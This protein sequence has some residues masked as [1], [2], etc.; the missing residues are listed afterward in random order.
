MHGGLNARASRQR[1]YTTVLSVLARLHHKGLLRR[2]R[3]GRADVYVPALTR[4]EYWLARAGV[5]VDALVD[6]FGDEALAHFVQAVDGLED[7]KMDALRRLA[8][9]RPALPGAVTPRRAVTSRSTVGL[10]A[11]GV[12]GCGSGR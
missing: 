4:A 9:E 2:R 6:H 11:S 8:D 5:E 12:A 3:V 10:V 7:D 1:A